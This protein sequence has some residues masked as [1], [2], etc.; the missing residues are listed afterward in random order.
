MAFIKLGP[1]RQLSGPIQLFNS[2]S[3][4]CKPD[5][6][7]SRW[8]GLSFID[9]WAHLLASENAANP[10]AMRVCGLQAARFKALAKSGLPARFS[11]NC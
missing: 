4:S 11:D 1:E 10:C 6:I 7:S 9:F 5:E 2:N 3:Q 8:Q